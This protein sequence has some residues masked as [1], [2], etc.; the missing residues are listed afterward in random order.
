M[1]YNPWGCRESDTTERPTHTDVLVADL[2][3]IVV[4]GVSSALAHAYG[5]S[6][7]PHLGF[8]SLVVKSGLGGEWGE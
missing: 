3:Y 7:A 8:Y 2:Q 1:D 6:S 5:V 4:S